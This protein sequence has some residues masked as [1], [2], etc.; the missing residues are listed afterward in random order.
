LSALLI[1]FVVSAAL[2]APAGRS[3][4]EALASR[5]QGAFQ[6]HLPADVLHLLA[7]SAAALPAMAALLLVLLG[8]YSLARQHRFQV[9]Y[10]YCVLVLPFALMW[11]LRP[12]DLYPRFFTYWLPCF[13]VFATSGIGWIW[14]L[15][16]RMAAP[17]RV[18]LGSLFVAGAMI[19]TWGWLDT[20]NHWSIRELSF[21][22]DPGYRTVSQIMQSNGRDG[23]GLCAVGA[24]VETWNW[25]L[26]QAV[27]VPRSV[28][29][30]LEFARAHVEVRC[31][32]YDAP[33]QGPEQEQLIAFL[34]AHGER[35]RIIKRDLFVYRYRAD[36]SN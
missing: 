3:L 26:D 7:G 31:A 27:F 4:S 21:Y 6:P 17:V 34:A 33:W 18:M 13:L 25:Y 22:A 12:F 36:P 29:A 1:T 2:Y 19:M 8:S 16:Y 9:I 14:H 32:C 11:V 20:L 24:D 35:R 30:L 10:L 5:G 15:T 23:V 28:D